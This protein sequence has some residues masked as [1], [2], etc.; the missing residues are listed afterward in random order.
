MESETAAIR[1]ITSTTTGSGDSSRIASDD[2]TAATFVG[3]GT[4]IDLVRVNR[5]VLDRASEPFPTLARTLDALHIASALLA[6]SRYKALRF[7]SR[8]RLVPTFTNIVV[9]NL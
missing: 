7:P 6:Q 9:N 1:R 5:A 3:T 4:G 8:R 2:L